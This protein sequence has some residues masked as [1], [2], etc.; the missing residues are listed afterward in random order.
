MRRD[1]QRKTDFV[2]NLIA[3]VCIIGVGSMAF[4]GAAHVALG[5]ESGRKETVATSYSANF[6]AMGNMQ[7][8]ALPEGYV[9]P[10]YQLVDNDLEYY[11]NIK[12]TSADLTREQ[13]AE[14]GVP[15]L[16]RIF[17]VD[18][19]GKVIEMTYDP[20]QNGH[21]ATWSGA[22]RPDGPKSSPEADVQSYYFRLDAVTGE[23][24][25]VFHD[26]VLN[27]SANTGFDS[28]LEQNSGDYES[29]AKEMAV[30]FG[31]IKGSINKVEYSGQGRSG[32]DPTI[33]FNL[34][35]EGGDRAQLVFSRHDKE[36]LGIVYDAGMKDMDI[37][38]QEALEFEKRAA[39][40]LKQHPDA[41][42]YEEY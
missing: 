8:R 3:A 26:R 4:Q 39:E 29:L 11:K 15:E 22:W 7:G 18:L 2:K 6:V 31:A 23:L 35:G 36:L 42:T 40:Y 21:R 37:S 16:Y 38:E 12:P 17:G 20:A 10:E 14:L 33:S 1:N 34:T 30:K 5:M 28:G 24:N 19:N 41:E 32:N 13:A 27:G 25:A 9:K